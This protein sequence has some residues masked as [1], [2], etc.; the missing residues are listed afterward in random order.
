MVC[1]WRTRHGQHSALLVATRRWPRSRRFCRRIC[2][3]C[4]RGG[5]GGFHWSPKHE[6]ERA[7]QLGHLC[8]CMN[9]SYIRSLYEGKQHQSVNLLPL[10]PSK[11][12]AAVEGG[13]GGAGTAVGV[14]PRPPDQRR[15]RAAQPRLE[16]K[17]AG[18]CIGRRQKQQVGSDFTCGTLLPPRPLAASAEVGGR[19][20][21][22]RG[23]G[24]VALVRTAACGA[25]PSGRAFSS[26][27]SLDL[28]G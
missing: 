4:L 23:G 10:F 2:L 18:D 19:R 26:L 1:G 8:M 24:A 5:R 7:P 9:S 28:Q 12:R 22:H 25:E 14:A 11:P 13:G 3:V 17:R 6:S 15:S 16:E 27:P 20:V 21:V